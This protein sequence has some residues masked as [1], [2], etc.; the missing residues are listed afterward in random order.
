MGGPERCNK[1]FD[2][3]SDDHD[4]QEPGKEAT[5]AGWATDVD[6]SNDLFFRDGLGN[7]ERHD[8]DGKQANG[9][10]DL[11]RGSVIQAAGEGNQSLFRGNDDEYQ[12]G[13]G[14]DCRHAGVDD[15]V[16][17]QQAF[18]GP[19]LTHVVRNVRPYAP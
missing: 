10:N 7:L 4:K 14:K 12:G 17:E 19:I 1:S 5:D 2:R 18:H 11:L 8:C 16:N 3:E 13:A 6:I 15:R 9:F